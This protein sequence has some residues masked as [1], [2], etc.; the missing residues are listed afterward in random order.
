MNVTH[1]NCI[2]FECTEYNVVTF[3]NQIKMVLIYIHVTVLTSTSPLASEELY[4]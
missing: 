2:H 1:T 4:H 3:Q